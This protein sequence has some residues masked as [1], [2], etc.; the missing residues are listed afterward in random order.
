M[1][2]NCYKYNIR[3]GKTEM[4]Y[5]ITKTTSG[6]GEREPYGMKKS[7][8]YLTLILERDFSKKT[9]SFY[10]WGKEK[11]LKLDDNPKQQLLRS[12]EQ[13]RIRKR[14]KENAPIRRARNALRNW[15][16]IFKKMCHSKFWE[17]IC[18]I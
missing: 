5:Y 18:Q 15:L 10:K 4:K 8:T 9:W 11:V 7:L 6:K 3:C 16:Q 12:I 17:R 2:N 13:S 14:V 1:Y